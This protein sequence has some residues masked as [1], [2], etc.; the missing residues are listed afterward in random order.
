[1]ASIYCT[2]SSIYLSAIFGIGRHGTGEVNKYRTEFDWSFEASV[3]FNFNIITVIAMIKM[4][5]WFKLVLIVDI[6]CLWPVTVHGFAKWGVV[7]GTGRLTI[8]W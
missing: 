4:D 6:G 5:I 8:N 1:M 2:S 7:L 3:C